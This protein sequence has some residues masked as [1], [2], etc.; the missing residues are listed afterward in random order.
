MRHRSSTALP[1]S[2]VAHVAEHRSG[3]VEIIRNDDAVQVIR[4]AL[5]VDDDAALG[6]KRHRDCELVS[7]RHTNR[8]GGLTGG[9]LLVNFLYGDEKVLAVRLEV[10]KGAVDEPDV[11]S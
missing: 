1:V 10:R 2:V 5:V 9:V 11:V 4:R 7:E 8:G 6:V 3:C